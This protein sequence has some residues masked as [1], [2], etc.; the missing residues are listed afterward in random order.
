[1]PNAICLLRC[2]HSAYYDPRPK[3]GDEVYCRRCAAYTRV[4]AASDEWAWHCP[5]CHTTRP[6]GTDEEGCRRSARTHQR[7]YHHVVVLRK[8][9]DT[10]EL[11]EPEGQGELSVAGERIEWVKP[12]QGALR[13][14]VD[15]VIVQRGQSNG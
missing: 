8:G 9:Y 5:V 10:V 12:H 6:H 15:K 13:A 11:V 7:K 4:K 1:M 2:G 14:L 3:T